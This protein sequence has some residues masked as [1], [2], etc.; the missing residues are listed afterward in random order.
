MSLLLPQLE[1]AAERI[2]AIFGSFES[3]DEGHNYPWVNYLWRSK[4]FRRAHLDII[5]ARDTSRLGHGP[6]ENM[7]RFVVHFVASLQ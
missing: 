1:D 6:S 3:Y 2:K 5:D 7:S 4:L